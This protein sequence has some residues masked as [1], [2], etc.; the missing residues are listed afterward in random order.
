MSGS[1]QKLVLQL[2]TA[3]SQT[4]QA[5]QAIYCAFERKQSGL[6]N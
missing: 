1:I 5:R 6:S 2:K 3:I 4:I